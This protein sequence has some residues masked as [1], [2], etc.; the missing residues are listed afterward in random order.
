M[1]KNY[2]IKTRAFL[3]ILMIFS[4]LIIIPFESKV[5]YSANGLTKQ[6]DVVATCAPPVNVKDS[7][8]LS[9]VLMCIPGIL[10]K[11]NELRQN[12]CFVAR[13]AYDAVRYELDPNFCYEQDAYRTCKFIVGEIFAL[14]PMHLLEYYRSAISEL[15]ANP[16]GLLYSTAMKEAR[17]IVNFSCKESDGIASCDVVSNPVFAASVYFTA[18]TDLLGVTQT[19]MEMFENGFD[20][21]TQNDNY[22]ENIGDIRTELEKVLKY[23]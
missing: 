23:S 17:D 5:A 22:C 16:V 12:K 20:F 13:C 11:M 3:S 10:E 1:E 6:S 9:V 19:L 2:K 21:F 18:A 15:I 7:L 14:P 8:V 4:L